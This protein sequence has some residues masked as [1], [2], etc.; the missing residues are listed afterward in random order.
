MGVIHRDMKPENLILD[1]TG[2]VWVMDFGIAIPAR[3]ALAD[4]VFDGLP[5]RSAI[6]RPSSSWVRAAMRAPIST[7]W[8]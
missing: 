6:S 3:A 4:T 8:A 2:Q 1:P 7:R 5:G